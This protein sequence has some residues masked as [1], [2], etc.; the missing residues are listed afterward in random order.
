MNRSLL[1]G[2][3][4]IAGLSLTG[5]VNRQAQAEAKE[6]QTVLADRSV[7]V[8]VVTASPTDFV[9]T[10]QI[11]G[12]L[13]SGDDSVLTAQAPGRLVAVFVKDGD[14]VTAGQVLARQDTTD[15]QTRIRQ[16]QSQVAAA[17]ASLRQAQNDAVVR[18]Q[19]SSSAVRA[20]RAQLAQ[21]ESAL[22]RARNGARVE[23]RAQADAAVR[24]AKTALD[25][26]KSDLQRAERLFGEGAIS[27]RELDQYR[28]GHANAL[29]A[30]ENSLEQKRIVMNATR[31]E[32]LQSAEAGVRLARE[33]LQQ[34]LASQRADVQFG[35]RVDAARAALAG[36]E[37][38]EVLARQAVEDAIIRAPYSGRIAGKPL[39]PGQYLA[40]GSPFAR[41]VGLEGIYFEGDVPESQVAQL[42]PGMT[43]A[44][45]V[46]AL[47]N[48]ALT[49]T[50]AAVNPSGESLGRLFK[51]RISLDNLPDGL[52]SGMFAR[53]SVELAR[54]PGAIL[55]PPSAVIGLG[56]QRTVWIAAGT[57]AAKRTVTV[58]G[59]QS[60]RLRV[61]GV[62]E[63]E[64]VVVSGQN[65]LSEGAVIRIETPKEQ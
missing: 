11:S 65:Q 61:I 25:I 16:A 63:G 34:A 4:L 42:K 12:N 40:P 27:Q 50:I 58:N 33:N 48:Q 15:A 28:L 2:I 41:I 46:D 18:P 22:L 64:K 38:A 51:V 19:E 37:D 9:T 23:E 57:K 44:V 3:F 56:T 36:A 31:S 53:G 39:Q 1:F 6:T 32:D 14:A 29:A 43:V 59:S 17:R 20:A 26:A 21:A 8:Q 24:A 7:P 35:D 52:R 5:C 54:D 55:L 10:L 30:Y 13:T 45:T 60:N 47:K 49:G 62:R